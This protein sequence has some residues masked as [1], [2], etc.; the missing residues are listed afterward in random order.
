MQSVTG[1]KSKSYAGPILKSK[2]TFSAT[3]PSKKPTDKKILE[4]K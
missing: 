1:K 4:W 2:Y 3:K